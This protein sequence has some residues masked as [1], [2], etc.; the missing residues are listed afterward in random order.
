MLLGLETFSY[1][2]A[3]AFG[4]MDVFDFI[5]RTAELGLDGVQINAEG[6]RLGHLGSDDPS[7]LKEVRQCIQ[8]HHLFVEV[9]T[10]GTDP[11]HLLSLIDICTQLGADRLRTFSSFGGKVALELEKAKRDFPAVLDRCAE[12][13]V[14]IAFE[15]H[16]YESSHDIMD[17]VRHVGSP[18]LGAH[19]DVGNAMMVWEDPLEAT[20][21]MAAA[22]VST[23]FKD[24]LL[25]RVGKAVMIAG[26][27]LGT[28]SID[29]Q[30]C[31]SILRNQS[32]LSRLNIEVCYGYLAPFRVPP[33]S[34]C[35]AGLGTGSFTIA[36]P[37]YQPEI[38][39][40]FLLDAIA[41]GPSLQSFA[42]QELAESARGRSDKDRLVAY[43]DMAV[44]TSVDHVK[45]LRQATVID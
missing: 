8:E 34:G 17:V 30:A 12:T 29:L 10:C 14:K 35:G 24:H 31:Y 21:N 16:E 43:Q 22:A 28:G 41:K 37:P 6:R 39:A 1:H 9:D 13:G 32:A 40:P 7:F 4:R 42:W 26:V 11:H 38:V 33:T 2:L 25:I 3:F 45:R 20:T 27:P 44:V 5:E 23:H 36:E 18:Y 15:N 19:I